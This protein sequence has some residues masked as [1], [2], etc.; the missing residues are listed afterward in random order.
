[1]II[2]QLINNAEV[3]ANAQGQNIVITADYT[4]ATT[5][6]DR[7]ALGQ[8]LTYQ[9]KEQAYYAIRRMYERLGLDF[10][11]VIAF[12]QDEAWRCGHGLS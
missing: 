2:A 9:E 7:V 3:H 1:M 10:D 6:R 5:A 11:R 8:T 4:V 12:Y